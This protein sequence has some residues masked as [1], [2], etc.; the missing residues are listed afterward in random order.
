MDGFDIDARQASEKWCESVEA[1]GPG[2][3]GRFG[4]GFGCQTL[5]KCV[6]KPNAS[7]GTWTPKKSDRKNQQC[8][9]TNSMRPG[10]N[11]VVIGLTILASDD[12][13]CHPGVSLLP[14]PLGWHLF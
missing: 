11:V 3:A 12:R 6:S 13:L 14:L 1:S 9:Y 5:P 10:N 2:R 7:R 8:A 4:G